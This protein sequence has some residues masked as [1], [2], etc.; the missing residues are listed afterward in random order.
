MQTKYN[1]MKYEKNNTLNK[2]KISIILQNTNNI[3]Q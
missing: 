3:I 2:N 1:T